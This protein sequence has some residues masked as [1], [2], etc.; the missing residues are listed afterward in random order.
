[1]DYPEKNKNPREENNRDCCWRRVRKKKYKTR[2][3]SVN[4]TKQISNFSKRQSIAYLWQMKMELIFKIIIA[5][6]FNPPSGHFIFIAGKGD[7]ED[8]S[9]KITFICVRKP[10]LMYL[11]NK[12]TFAFSSTLL[13]FLA[14]VQERVIGNIAF[15][16]MAATL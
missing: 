2:N 16:R 11:W 8:G 13:L 14:E 5:F 9:N 4:T 15:P 3:V 1:M 12:G 10:L 7:W 6:I